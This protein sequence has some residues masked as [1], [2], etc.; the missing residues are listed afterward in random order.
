MDCP[1]LEREVAIHWR[2]FLDQFNRDGLEV[3]LPDGR[4]IVYDRWSYYPECVEQPPDAVVHQ[5]AAEAISEEELIQRVHQYTG[6]TMTVL[7]FEVFAHFHPE[8]TMPIEEAGAIIDD[9]MP[10]FFEAIRPAVMEVFGDFL[11]SDSVL[12]A[13]I[14]PV[15][16]KPFEAGTFKKLER[17]GLPDPEVGMEEMS[18]GMMFEVMLRWFPKE[19]EGPPTISR[20]LPRMGAE[21]GR[22]LLRR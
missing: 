14:G 13:P 11:N 6:P 19:T 8:T 15:L 12:I 4:R 22:M 10:T 3:T 18:T 16:M 20:D 7:G 17:A 9:L 5:W 2:G 21:L 1:T